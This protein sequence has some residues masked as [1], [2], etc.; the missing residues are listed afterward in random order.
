MLVAIVVPNPDT[1]RAWA[2]DNG[3]ADATTEALCADAAVKELVQ[4]DIQTRG[5]VRIRH[6]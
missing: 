6:T 4:R 2:R 5:K 1:L 3:R